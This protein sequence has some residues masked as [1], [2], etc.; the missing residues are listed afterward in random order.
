VAISY[1]EIGGRISSRRKELNLTQENV[2]ENTNMSINQI[3]NIENS[4]SIPSIE[5]VMKL[6]D[7]LNTT[8]DYLLLGINKDYA[9]NEILASSLCQ[10]ILSCT[11]KQQR[12]INA[13]VTL[14]LKEDY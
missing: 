10:R 12:L 7:V 11:D 6:C 14:L 9:I 5:T 8:P 2:A 4:K 1:N 13:F 3:S